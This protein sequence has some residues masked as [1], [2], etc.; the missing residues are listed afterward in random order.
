EQR[1][2]G[3]NPPPLV[4]KPYRAFFT[5]EGFR[6]LNSLARLFK[7]RLVIPANAGIHN[8]TDTILRV[9]CVFAC[10]V[11]DLRVRGDD[12]LSAM[13]TFEQP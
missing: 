4:A 7:S 10:N 2:A 12:V 1:W 3:V 5:E 8:P 6:L 11:M 9:C 13:L